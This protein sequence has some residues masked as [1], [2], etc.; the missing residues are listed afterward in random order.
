MSDRR[1][2][3]AQLE[4]DAVAW[5]VEHGYNPDRDPESFEAAQE[6]QRTRSSSP[7]VRQTG[8]PIMTLIADALSPKPGAGE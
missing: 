8:Q 7:V 1:A 2:G 6:W 4:A 3:S 5:R